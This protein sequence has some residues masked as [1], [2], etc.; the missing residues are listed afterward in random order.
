MFN[1]RAIGSVAVRNPTKPRQ[2]IPGAPLEV[3]GMNSVPAVR[4]K[5]HPLGLFFDLTRH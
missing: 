2:G 1:G 5:E 4:S 3:S